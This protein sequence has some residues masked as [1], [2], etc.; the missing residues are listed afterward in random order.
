MA[1]D[2]PNRRTHRVQDTKRLVLRRR[3]GQNQ[4]SPTRTVS[5]GPSEVPS[6]TT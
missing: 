1:E 6:G 2:S 5:P 4:R 3:H